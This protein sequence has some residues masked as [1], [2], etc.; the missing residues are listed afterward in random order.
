MEKE[1]RRDDVAVIL[2]GR[3]EAMQMS[4]LVS[5]MRLFRRPELLSLSVETINKVC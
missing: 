4:L 2:F 5:K 3:S 1:A